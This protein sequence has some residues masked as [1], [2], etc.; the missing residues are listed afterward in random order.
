MRLVTHAGMYIGIVQYEVDLYR[1]YIFIG[2]VV[3]Y[4]K[5]F[6]TCNAKSVR[7]N[8]FFVF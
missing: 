2:I 4:T 6:R 1:C 5:S 3:D 7:M 8:L